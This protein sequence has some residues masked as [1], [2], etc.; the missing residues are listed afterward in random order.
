[1]SASLPVDFPPPELPPSPSASG[2]TRWADSPLAEDYPQHSLQ[3]QTT[4]LPTTTALSA[5]TALLTTTNRQRHSLQQ[6]TT[7]KPYTE[8][9]SDL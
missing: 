6:Q 8:T 7:L 1:M 9:T 5:T 2:W 4:A 3:Q